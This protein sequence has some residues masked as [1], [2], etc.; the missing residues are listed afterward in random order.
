MVLSFRKIGQSGG[1]SWW[2]V[3]YQRG[4]PRLVFMDKVVELVHGGS[5]IYGKFCALKKENRVFLG[6]RG[7]GGRMGNERP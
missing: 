5:V 6:G 2:R 4:L 7:E 3:C 1:A